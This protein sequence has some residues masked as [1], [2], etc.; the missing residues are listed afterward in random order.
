MDGERERR[1][2]PKFESIQEALEYIIETIGF[3]K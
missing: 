1:T 3:G 2:N